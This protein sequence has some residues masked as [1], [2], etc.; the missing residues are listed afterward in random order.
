MKIQSCS[1]SYADLT[2]VDMRRVLICDDGIPFPPEAAPKLDHLQ[3]GFSSAYPD[4]EAFSK[5]EEK[6]CG[7]SAVCISLF[8]LPSPSSIDYC[9]PFQ[10]HVQHIHNTGQQSVRNASVH[11]DHTCHSDRFL[12]SRQHEWVKDL[13][14][15]SVDRGRCSHHAIQHWPEPGP[16]CHVEMDNV[17]CM[18]S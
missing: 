14:R 10:P 7:F 5:V 2:L 1:K 4:D 3:V 12:Q 6:L 13:V 8:E 15:A 17:L 9:W 11:Y 18:S 16:G